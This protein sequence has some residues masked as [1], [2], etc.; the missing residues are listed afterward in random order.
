MDPEKPRLID[1]LENRAKDPRVA[2]V[3]GRYLDAMKLPR[4]AAVL[5]VGCGSGV[6][7]RSLAGRQDFNGSII[8]ID[9]DEGL[10]EAARKLAAEE[11]VSDLID[12]RIGDGHSL[13]LP[14]ASFD[15]VTAQTAISHMHDPKAVL[16][17]MAR[18]LKDGG[19]LAIFDGDYESRA[20][21]C[22]DHELARAAEA[23]WRAMQ[24]HSPRLIRDLPRLLAATEFE[25]DE[26]IPFVEFQ[27]GDAGTWPE[28]AE[29][30]APK[31][32]ETGLISSDQVKSWVGALKEDAKRGTV[33][34]ASN[35]YAYI[36]RRR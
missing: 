28:T 7:A 13:E 26:V 4:A 27:I 32:V 29:R 33:F 2:E 20:F 5:D 36:A 24:G 25:I 3:R 10:L 30:F 6:V 8:A 19:A 12:F 22:E 34:T 14:D 18:V 9:K 23:A 31:M 16:V 1:V 21:S 17:E 35:Y 15:G 11:G